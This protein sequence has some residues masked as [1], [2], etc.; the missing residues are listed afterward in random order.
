MKKRTTKERMGN[1]NKLLVK[2]RKVRKEA[3]FKVK[4]KKINKN[5]QKTTLKTYSPKKQAQ[6][7]QVSLL[8]HSRQNKKLLTKQS[9]NNKKLSNKRGQKTV[10]FKKLYKLKM[11]I[12]TNDE[13]NF[14]YGLNVGIKGSTKISS[15]VKLCFCDIS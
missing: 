12:V 3:Y 11:L 7:S 6:A 14:H 2:M 5:S 4:T 15:K 1:R 13:M 10:V 8:Q 9:R